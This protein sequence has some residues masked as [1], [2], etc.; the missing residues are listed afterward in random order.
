MLRA[1]TPLAG[2]LS[3]VH[4]VHAHAP[5][6]GMFEMRVLCAS[7]A[8]RETWPGAAGASLEGGAVHAA[9]RA[10]LPDRD[11]RPRPMIVRLAAVEERG[12]RS[13]GLRSGGEGVGHGEEA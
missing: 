2:P 1:H 7:V 11:L 5:R 4:R 8:A 6:C 9:V 3:A 13:G 10:I 12:L